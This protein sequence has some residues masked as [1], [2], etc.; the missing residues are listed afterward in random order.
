MV[1]RSKTPHLGEDAEFG[2]F[3]S[4]ML[5]FGRN[6]RYW[7]VLIE[8]A[9]YRPKIPEFKTISFNCRYQHQPLLSP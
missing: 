5:Y 2:M 4:K 9:I 8:N 1:I 3:R 7:G 6:S